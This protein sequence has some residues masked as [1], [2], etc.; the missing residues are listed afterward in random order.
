MDSAESCCVRKRIFQTIALVGAGLFHPDALFG[1]RCNGHGFGTGPAR[2]LIARPGNEENSP[3]TLGAIANR[4]IA[5]GRL[6]TFATVASEGDLLWQA[7]T[8]SLGAGA[9]SGAGIHPSSGGITWRPTE[10]QGGTTNRIAV[11]VR[12]KGESVSAKIRV[13]RTTPVEVCAG[14]ASF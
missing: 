11:I 2:P 13:F 7:L 4:T 12:D 3:P 6:L 14:V 9:P 1:T 8:F 10:F 5:E